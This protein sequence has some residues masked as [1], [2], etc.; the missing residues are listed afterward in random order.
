MR[1]DKDMAFVSVWEYTGDDKEAKLNKEP[2]K[3][4]EVEVKQRNYKTA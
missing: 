1:D 4:E 3:Y 2:L